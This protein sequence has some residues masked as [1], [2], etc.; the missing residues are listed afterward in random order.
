MIINMLAAIHIP[1]RLLLILPNTSTK[2]GMLK[3]ISVYALSIRHTRVRVAGFLRVWLNF[4]NVSL[5]IV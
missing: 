1:L 4:L 2:N 3:A 5:H